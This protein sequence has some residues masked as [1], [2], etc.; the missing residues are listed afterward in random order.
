MTGG[1]PGMSGYG[2][3]ASDLGDAAG[4][5]DG[6]ASDIEAKIGGLRS[7]VESLRDYW[8]G[9]AQTAFDTLMGDYDIYATMMHDALTDIASGLRGNMVN[10]TDAEQANL[11]NIKQ[12]DLPAPNF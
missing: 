10:Y 9:P 11:N 12:V 6:K 5:V 7:Y 4:Y 1:V 8:Q 3:T 2:V